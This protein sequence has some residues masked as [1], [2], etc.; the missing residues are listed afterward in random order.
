M[1]LSETG[2]GKSST[3]LLNESTRVARPLACVLCVFKLNAILL[4]L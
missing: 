2:S 3:V 1:G 4:Y